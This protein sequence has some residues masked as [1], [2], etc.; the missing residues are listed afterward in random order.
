MVEMSLLAILLQPLK[1]NM[2]LPV[3]HLRAL[4]L[5]PLLFLAET[6]QYHRV[7]ARETIHM[8]PRINMPRYYHYYLSY[9]LFLLLAWLSFS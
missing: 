9:E 8:T 1:Q 4:T 3:H 2:L 5:G 7:P 6:H